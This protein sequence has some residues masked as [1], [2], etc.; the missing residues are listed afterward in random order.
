MFSKMKRGSVPLGGYAA[1]MGVLPEEFNKVNI[2]VKYTDGTIGTT[3]HVAANGQFFLMSRLMGGDDTFNGIKLA[4]I[5]YLNEEG[6][7]TFKEIKGSTDVV[8]KTGSDFTVGY[9]SKINNLRWGITFNY[10]HKTK[11]AQ[12]VKDCGSPI[13][14][15]GFYLTEI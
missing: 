5:S 11:R 2:P 14:G 12:I 7:L 8:F 6:V 3:C 13:V 15:L 1:S 9:T 4:Q 10:C